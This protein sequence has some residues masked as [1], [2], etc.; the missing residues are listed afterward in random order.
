MS[1]HQARSAVR[2]VIVH[3][4]PSVKVPRE[5]AMLAGQT[6]SVCRVAP[7]MLTGPFAATFEQASARLS[8]LPRLFI[9][10]DGSF[11]WVSESGA[12]EWQIDGQLTDSA[13]GLMT[14]DLK[15]FGCDADWAAVL[16]AVDW[17]HQ[18]LLFQCV[19]LGIYLDEHQFRR[20]LSQDRKS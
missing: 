11:V 16:R 12:D 5:S 15:L 18:A 10:P 4:F 7:E 20:F 3:A 17:P 6:W 2:H 14:M 9:E 1:G 8:A 13:Q 19:Q